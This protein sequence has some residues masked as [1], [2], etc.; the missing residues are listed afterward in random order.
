MP[1]RT[2]GIFSAQTAMFCIPDKPTSNALSKP[3]Y[4]GLILICMSR[5]LD[6]T[7]RLT[8]LGRLKGKTAFWNNGKLVR[9]KA[10]MQ[11]RLTHGPNIPQFIQR[12]D[13][14]RSVCHVPEKSRKEA[15][16]EIFLWYPVA[17][18]KLLAQRTFS[19]R[20]N[21]TEASRSPGPEPRIA[22]E[23]TK[24]LQHQVRLSAFT[25]CWYHSPKP[26]V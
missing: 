24:Q 11:Q 20:W 22:R 18:V 4:Q 1:G 21:N 19:D 14:G 13:I 2:F 16:G 25:V 3:L 12:S 5:N 17:P 8:I 15:D 7:I 23:S 10:R 26:H 6:G 9:H